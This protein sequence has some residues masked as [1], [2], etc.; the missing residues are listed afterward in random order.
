MDDDRN[1]RDIVIDLRARF[2]AFEK[3]AGPILERLDAAAHRRAGGFSLARVGLEVARLVPGGAIAAV[4]AWV[5][6]R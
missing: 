1:T 3:R 2:E 4:V 5:L 6:H